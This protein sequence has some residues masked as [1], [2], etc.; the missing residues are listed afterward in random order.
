VPALIVAAMVGGCSSD[1]SARAL[2]EV[3]FQASSDDGEPLAGVIIAGNGKKLGVTA[4]DGTFTSHLRAR[5]GSTLR[6]RA[7]CPKGFREPLQPQPLTLRRFRSLDRKADEL[8]VSI[9]CRATERLVALVVNTDRRPDLPVVMDGREI[10]RTNSEGVAHLALRMAPNTTFRVAL[11]TSDQ[12]TLRPKS[13]TATF[14]VGDADSLV[15]FDQ[16]FVEEIKR[17]KRRRRKKAKPPPV[18]T[19]PNKIVGP[20]KKRRWRRV[21][22]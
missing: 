17:K 18:D 6:P 16:A 14:T 10:G 9:E 21:G 11:D 1:K 2:F 3:Q 13:P 19:R 8:R 7:T 12:R 5:E 22:G 4:A 20:D 15:L